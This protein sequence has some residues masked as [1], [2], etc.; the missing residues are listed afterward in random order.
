VARAHLAC[1][2]LPIAPPGLR[3]ARRPCAWKR[4]MQPR[5]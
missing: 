5:A 3:L 2:R 1:P 4:R